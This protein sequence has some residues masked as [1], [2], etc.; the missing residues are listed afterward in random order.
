MSDADITYIESELRKTTSP[1]DKLGKW[2]PTSGHWGNAY[3][4]LETLRSTPTPPPSPPPT[5]P[6]PTP[7]GVFPDPPVGAVASAPLFI[8]TEAN[9]VTQKL[10]V[11]KGTNDGI[12]NMVW[13]PKPS[14]GVWTLEDC[15]ADNISAV[16]PRSLNGT[17]EAGFWIGQKTNAARL[18]AANNAW[19][20][21]WTGCMCDGSVISDFDLSGNPHVGLYCEHV[22]RN[23]TFERFLINHAGD[24]NAVNVE[25]WYAD[26]TY[27]PLLPYNGKAGSYNLTF[28]NFDITVPAGKWAFFLDAGTFGCTIQNGTIRGAGNGVSHPK[29]LVD[30]SSP[31]VIDWDSIEFLATGTK[32]AVN[33]DA[34]G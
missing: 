6:P 34:I 23:T 22:T 19:M 29:N 3:A 27:G 25:W 14:T 13:P 12:G 8:R 16:P 20:G 11:A 24:G 15:I 5:P 4:R 10:D 31:N 9:A 21:M 26:S 2:P 1:G 7:A 30:A 28:Q 33:N 18:S 32:E 17:G